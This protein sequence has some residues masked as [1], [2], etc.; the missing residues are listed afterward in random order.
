MLDCVT[1]SNVDFSTN[2]MYILSKLKYIV[3]P[4]MH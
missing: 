1:N 4:A 2:L 3:E